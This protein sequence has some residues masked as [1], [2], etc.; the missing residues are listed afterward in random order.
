MFFPANLLPSIE[1]T[2]PN[3]TKANIHQEHNNTT[4]PH[5][6][7]TLKPGLVTPYYLQRGNGAGPILCTSQGNMGRGIVAVK[8]VQ[9]TDG[10]RSGFLTRDPSRRLLTR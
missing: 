9:G 7:K 8:H 10:T 3:T 5:K 2:K 1:E 4:T 6:R